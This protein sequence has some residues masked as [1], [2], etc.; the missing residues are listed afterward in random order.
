MFRTVQIQGKKNEGLKQAALGGFRVKYN[1]VIIL[2]RTVQIWGKKNVG[3]KQVALGLLKAKS[4]GPKQ[5]VSYS[6]NSG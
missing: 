1:G 4:L 5:I 3:W 2:Y 6:T